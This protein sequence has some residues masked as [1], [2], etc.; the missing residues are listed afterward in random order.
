MAKIQALSALST[1]SA[2]RRNP[3]G[4]PVDFGKDGHAP[5]MG[6]LGYVMFSF[7]IDTETC[8]HPYHGAT[9]GPAIGKYAPH[10]RKSEFIRTE[11]RRA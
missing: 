11:F 5:S 4:R 6:R 3:T 1:H 8:Q 10:F 9:H 7:A 2:F